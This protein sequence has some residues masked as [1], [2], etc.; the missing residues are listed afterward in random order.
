MSKRHPDEQVR[1]DRQIS[2]REALE[3]ICA[4]TD[5][6][7]RAVGHWHGTAIKI[8][9]SALFGLPPE[10]WSKDWEQIKGNLPH[11]AKEGLASAIAVDPSRYQDH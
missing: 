5:A 11:A 7:G 8:A 3:M 10:L 4:S 1:F 2:L 9:R 6:Q